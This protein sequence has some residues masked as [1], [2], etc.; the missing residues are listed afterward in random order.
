MGVECVFPAEREA[1]AA[2][3]RDE[4][5]GHDAAADAGRRGGE[6]TR[7]GHP[8]IGL[9]VPN[10]LTLRTVMDDE[11]LAFTHDRTA[12]RTLWLRRRRGRARNAEQK[13]S[14][15]MR[16]TWITGLT[17]LVLGTMLAGCDG[18][19]KEEN[20]LLLEENQ[21]LR[22][23]LADRNDALETAHEELMDR[24]AR[25]AQLRRD[26]DEASQV[27]ANTPRDPFGNIAGVTGSYSAGEVTAIIE[28]DILFD[29]GKATLKPAA[30][31]AL[32]EVARIITRNYP[33]RTIRVAGHTDTD[34]I[35]KSGFK[36]NYHLGFERAYAVREYLISRGVS[37]RDVYVASH[38]P[39][40][41]L[42]SKK[43][44]RRVEIAV[45]LN[46]D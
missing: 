28:S 43:E 15:A 6:R 35:R 3:F 40:R 17:V 9:T 26:L 27:Q 39:D 32:T 20:A 19:L 25:L 46:E 38:G 34:P 12:E 36:S 30:K 29:S 16:R 8:L 18:N 21:G 1:A 45:V 33:G 24:D 4:R 5:A 14:I 22:A 2:G 7:S 23:Q 10:N 42:A 11:L 31:T 37:K 44:S 13:G 41:S